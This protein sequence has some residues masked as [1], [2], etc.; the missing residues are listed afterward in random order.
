MIRRYCCFTWHTGYLATRR[1]DDA[2]IHYY[3][4]SWFHRQAELA[5]FKLLHPVFPSCGTKFG[6]VIPHYNA[7][8]RPGGLLLIAFGREVQFKFFVFISLTLTPCDARTKK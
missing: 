5:F 6:G 2:T 1:S 3:Y 8:K 7:N 4:T